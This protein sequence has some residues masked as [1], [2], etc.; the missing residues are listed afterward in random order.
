MGRVV[1]QVEA[2]ALIV[3]RE[4]EPTDSAVRLL[5]AMKMVRIEPECSG[6]QGAAGS[7]M[8]YQKN[9][10]AGVRSEQVSPKLLYP[11]V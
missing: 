6:D 4:A 1:Q 5:D 2:G 8:R 7:T 10:P 3:R 9:G 11:Q